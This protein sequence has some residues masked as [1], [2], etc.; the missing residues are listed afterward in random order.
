MCLESPAGR[1]LTIDSAAFL[2]ESQ[3]I[4]IFSR[5]IAKGN[6]R[7]SEAVASPSFIDTK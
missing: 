5:R 6:V 3:I 4:Y 7:G 1:S 2:H